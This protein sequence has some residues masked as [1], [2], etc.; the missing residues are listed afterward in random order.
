M[1]R[2]I[3]AAAAAA[4]LVS[5][6]AL[7][8]SA[9]TAT[10]ASAA[11]GKSTASAASAGRHT[12]RSG[13][14]LAQGATLR[15]HNGRYVATVTA[16]GRLLVRRGNTV[17]WHTHRAHGAHPRLMLH[18]SG[19]LT[20]SVGSAVQWT[21]STGGSH[22]SV[23]ALRNDGVLVLRSSGGQVWSSARGNVCRA[24]NASGRR[25]DIDLT[26]Q[27][28]KLCNND[29]QLLTTPITSG[30]S[31]VGDG[32]PTGTWHLQA[33]QRDTT[34]YPAAGGAYP[35]H[36]WMPYDGAY[37]MH[38]SPWQNFPYGSSKYRTQ[39]SHGCVHFPRAAIAWMFA[40]API[41][42]TVRIHY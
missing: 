9:S 6:V 8:A 14:S 7:P 17:I 12:L 31:S 22:A 16:A 10:T 26:H 34:L 21:T 33:K 39:G 11:T 41:G 35:V 42:T 4:T 23:L 28:A 29:R 15:S 5:V 30:A 36:Y 2:W 32:T 19:N 37:G 1:I 27:F 3:C 13:A 24:D 18:R 25:V 20:L 40:W 38:D